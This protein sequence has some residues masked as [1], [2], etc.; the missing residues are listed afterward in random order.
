[1]EM[2]SRLPV[3]VAAFVGRERERAEVGNL[4][5]EMRVATLTGSGGCGKTRLAM[6]V[7]G[8]VASRF[9]DGVFWVDLA[10]VSEPE[11]VAPSIGAAIGVRGRSGEPLVDAL[12]EQARPRHLLV[13]LDNCEHLVA[14]CAR[15]VSRLSSGC[16]QLH[17]LATS[18]ERLSVEGEAVF[19]LA[20]LQ[21]P[22]A[23]ARSARSVASSEA[24]RLFEVRARQLGTGFQISDDNA[25]HVAEICRRLDGIPLAIE[26]AAARVRVLAP[27][28]I[29]VGLSHRFGLLTD[30]L[31]GAPP[32]QQTLEAS[33]DW[34]YELLDQAQKLTLARLSVFSASFEFDAAEAVVATDVIDSSEV[35]GLIAALVDRCL[36]QV[37]RHDGRARYRLL[38]TIRMYAW[39]RLAE[40]DEPDR[41]RDRHLEFYVGLVRAA[42]AGLT[43]AHPE[44]WTARLAA[45]LDDLRAAM[46][47]AVASRDPRGLVDI[48]EPIM[49]F[50]FDHG[51]SAEM[52]RRLRA[53]VNTR[54][55]RDHDR[56]RGLVAA[57]LLAISSGEPAR[58]HASANRAIDA[59]RAAE[60]NAPLGLG[61]SI[62]ALS[63]AMSGLASS[64]QVL[65]DAEEAVEH[66]GQCG[67]AATHA[68]VLILA[69]VA[70]VRTH[71]IDA[72]SHLLERAIEVCESGEVL[73]H[74]LAAHATLG[75]WPVP[76]GSL[77]RTRQ[78]AQYGLE[79]SR[80]VG[81]PGWVALGLTGLGAADVL[82]GR[83]DKARDRLSE[84]HETLRRRGLD[85]TQFAGAMLHWLALCAY[86]S[87]DSATARTTADTIVGIGLDR[88]N[89]WDE[90]VG[91]W[92]L[93]AIAQSEDRHDEARTHLERSLER[94][95]DPHLP[96]PRGRAALG[97]ADLARMRGEFEDAWKL[98]HEGLEV[99]A[100]Y[101]DRVGSAGA[102][103]AIAELAV[104]FGKPEQ[105]LRLLAASQGFHTEAG[106]ERF[107]MEAERFARADHAAWAA[108]DDAEAVEC[109]EA[110]GGLSLDD[111]IAYARRGWGERDRPQSGWASLTP[112]E[113]DLVR[114][115]AQGC[116]NVEIGEHLFISVNTVKKHLSH[117]YAKVDV[118]GRAA[119]AAEVARREL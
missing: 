73:F 63:G 96:L 1:M 67:E 80:Q 30:G 100:A 51:L 48:A 107:P 22:A 66:A 57:A 88:E 39:Q 65:A 43:G 84:A 94:S 5:M 21:L 71:T 18:R 2:S 74:L 64:D 10:G 9:S 77:D 29:A 13:V 87:G 99:L 70:L 20:P 49:R 116:T 55:A 23:G 17:V 91:E 41:V 81:R 45:D 40:L 111:A 52:Q 118:D 6:E 47:W 42:G 95:T 89:R 33:L 4:V 82:Q 68:H 24:A 62:R 59:A 108:L 104:T 110:G 38:E 7:A 90:A 78:H 46:A 86:A 79:L 19:Q 93:G 72:G 58:A 105:A 61:L 56:V 36:L 102:L 31:R 69:G 75:I 25:W 112:A 83:Y 28:Q 76:T 85:R 8:E 16:P 60:V 11:M 113:V 97:L 109:W 50:W 117:V 32:R 35:F 37:V 15:L 98:A 26:L 103:E 12:T 34:S 54:A 106:I 14:A 27:T 119:L 3:G 114:L 92:L 101:G 44:G 53:A 115:V